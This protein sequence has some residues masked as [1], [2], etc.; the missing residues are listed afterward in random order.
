MFKRVFIFLCL[1]LG[2]A[3]SFSN[4]SGS[5]SRFSRE[6]LK[7]S[8]DLGDSESR[9]E[10]EWKPRHQN[11]VGVIG[12]IGPAASALLYKHVVDL[13][14][15]TRDD[16]HVP[17]L[18]YN[19][20][21]IPNNN[22][23]VLGK[24]PRSVPAMAYTVKQLE[25]AGA[26]HIAIP[27]NTAHAFV[28]ELQ[29]HNP[30]P[31]INMLTIT[32]KEALKA[33]SSQ[34]DTCVGLMCTKGTIQSEIY[35]KALFAVGKEIGVNVKVI[36][37]DEEGIDVVQNCIL[38]IKSGQAGNPAVLE[39]LKSQAKDLVG[40]G[41]NVLVLGCTELPLVLSSANTQDLGI[42]VLDPMTILA[43]EIIELTLT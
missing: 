27:C 31:I 34:K 14:P 8:L 28:D 11:L 42:P 15:C 32:A 37:P 22:E 41:A 17:L 16:E 13:R 40:R 23:A 20:P 9:Q 33:S 10:M 12:G 1:I 21:Q 35:Q 4:P 39:K 6:P 29:S 30:L 24:G 43:K 18:I 5:T 38:E 2:Q 19:N 25:K 7:M 26:T 36:V 3:S